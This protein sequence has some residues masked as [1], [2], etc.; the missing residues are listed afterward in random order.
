MKLLIKT[1]AILIGVAGTMT[2]AA[3]DAPAEAPAYATA[4]AV[5]ALQTN[6]NIV[7]TLIAG[8]LVFFMQ[9]GFAMV[10][11]GFT[12]AKNSANIMMKNMMDFATGSFAFFLVGSAFMFGKT[13]FGLIGTDGFFM[14]VFESAADWNWTFMF[15]QTM[16]CATA[17]TIVSGAMA[18][19]TKFSSY[20]IYSVIVSAVIYP[21]S[22]KW[23]WGGLY[24]ASSAG[25]LES[26][27]FC[28]FAGSTVVHSV[29]GWLALAGAI[30]L[31]PRIGKYGADGKPRMIPGHNLVIGTLGVLILWVGWF[32]FNPGSTT[33]GV[34]DI[35][36]IALVTNL[37]AIAGAITA[38]SAAWV[39]MKKP[40]LSMTLNGA[41]AGLVA[42]TAPC[43]TVTPV[44]GLIIGAI[45]GVL[46]VLS[47]FAIDRIGIDDPVGAVSVHGMNGLWGTLA[48]GL[49]NAEAV[50]GVSEANT[51]LFYGGG[52]HQLGVQLLGAVVFFAWAFGLGMLMFNVLRKTVGLRVNAEEELRGLDIVEHGNDAY[53]GFQI[54]PN[55]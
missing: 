45:A 5:E 40:D 6:L 12:R 17:A 23:A 29:G 36:R 33:S 38:M 26:F 20:L 11:T 30:T 3:A 27:G 37:G 55:E 9:A 54:F 51:G 21:I 52:F 8:V 4:A 2:L 19:R 18:E 32:G 7:W 41:L 50:L 31:G 42:I 24:G 13:A 10:E 14:K 22:G 47:V 25:W 1:A 53:A 44:G 34:G 15:F 28:D 48:C 39:I 35:G 43:N 49:F 16:F 46:V